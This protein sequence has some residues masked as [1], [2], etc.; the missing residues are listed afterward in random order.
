MTGP[1]TI[2][3][4]QPKVPERE[5][6]WAALMRA[7]LAGDGAA[8][9]RLLTVIVP[10]LRRMAQK[11]LSRAGNAEAEDVVQEILLA[12]HLKR[13][14]WLPDQPFTPWLNA[15]ARHKLIDAMRRRGRRGEV[16]IEDLAEE[17]PDAS[18]APESSKGELARLVGKL[19]GRQL[20][21]V[22]AISIDGGGI[23]DTAAKFGMSEGAV[24]VALHRGLKKLAALYRTTDE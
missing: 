20:E 2:R 17:I 5:A 3:M 15:I 24:R 22:R 12:V 19:D 9:G 14:T 13:Q 7:G 18:P 4:Q 21:V 6:E 23:P 10:A 11:S 1:V 16:P 8:Y